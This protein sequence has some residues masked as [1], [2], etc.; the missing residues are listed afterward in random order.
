M[1]FNLNLSAKISGFKP[2]DQIT[3]GVYAK[4]KWK[5]D[6]DIIKGMKK[7]GYKVLVIWEG[8]LEKELDK[9]TK[10]IL[11]FAKS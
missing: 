8:K 6:K 2:N 4:D 11:K 10:K 5:K 7:Q 1:T 3:G 9:T